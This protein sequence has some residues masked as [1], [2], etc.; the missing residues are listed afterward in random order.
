MG[1]KEQL[2]LGGDPQKPYRETSDVAEAAGRI[3]LAV[4]RRVARQDPEDLDALMSLQA[5]LDRSWR[6][7]IDGLRASR[8]TDG[9]IGSHLGISK[10][11]VAQRWPRQD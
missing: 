3:V 9:E 7:A 11:A 2:S 6:I 8:Y 4:G 5:A 10:Q 1:D